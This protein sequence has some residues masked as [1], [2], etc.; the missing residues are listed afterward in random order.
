MKNTPSSP[1]SASATWA[2]IGRDLIAASAE[3]ARLWPK[4]TDPNST[5]AWLRMRHCAQ[6]TAQQMPC[7]PPA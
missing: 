2:D 3:S 6:Q 7:A 1:S 5:R 4:F